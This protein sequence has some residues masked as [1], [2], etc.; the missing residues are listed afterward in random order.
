MVNI[1]SLLC[2]GSEASWEVVHWGC[3]L[4]HFGA[5]VCLAHMSWMC[6]TCEIPQPGNL[7]TLSGAR[8]TTPFLK[9]ALILWLSMVIII[10]LLV[11]KKLDKCLFN[12]FCGTETDDRSFILTFGS[13]FGCLTPEFPVWLGC[14]RCLDSVFSLS[15]QLFL[16]WFQTTRWPPKKR[17]KKGAFKTAGHVLSYPH[18]SYRQ[19]FF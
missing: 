2:L 15:R 6:A 3:H 18:I 10:I 8:H 7:L 5:A 11:S 16:T 14:G 1:S 12:Y 4:V 17:R 13:L 19:S 9:F